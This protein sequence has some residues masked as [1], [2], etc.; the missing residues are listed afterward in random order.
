MIFDTDIISSNNMFPEMMIKGIS[1]IFPQYKYSII[2]DSHLNKYISYLN[3]INKEYANVSSSKIH[4]IR[5][6]SRSRWNKDVVFAPVAKHDN[7]QIQFFS[8]LKIVNTQEIKVSYYRKK[9]EVYIK[10]EALKMWV[11]F[12][13][14]YGSEIY[15]EEGMNELA[16]NDGFRDIKQFFQYFKEEYVGKIIHW[17]D[18]IYEV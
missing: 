3:S 16:V 15:N 18:K 12:Y 2:V 8:N 13:A 14:D 10:S 4:T 17:T 5:K 7:D 9:P 11:I 1:K 6:D